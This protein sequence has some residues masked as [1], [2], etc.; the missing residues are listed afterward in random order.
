MNK[1]EIK[2][3]LENMDNLFNLALFTGIILPLLLVSQAV[4]NLDE[5]T[6]NVVILLITSVLSMIMLTSLFLNKDKNK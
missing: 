3:Q 5:H 6:V 4:F 1:L 2:S